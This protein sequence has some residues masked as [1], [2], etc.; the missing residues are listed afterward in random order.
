MTDGRFSRN[1]SL[2]DF[3]LK[4]LYRISLKQDKKFRR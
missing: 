2:L 1:S 3:L 4:I